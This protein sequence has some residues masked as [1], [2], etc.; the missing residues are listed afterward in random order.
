MYLKNASGDAFI[1][2]DLWIGHGV[3]LI[4]YL[5]QPNDCCS[6]EVT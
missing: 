5:L 3:F 6:D 2:F 4:K 1:N